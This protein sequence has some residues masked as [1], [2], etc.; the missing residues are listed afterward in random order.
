[1]AWPKGQ[2]RPLGAGRQKGT[3]NIRTAQVME[4]LSK[5]KGG[6]GKL[7]FNPLVELVECYH[8][9]AN[10]DGVMHVAVKC[11][12]ILMPYVY[13]KITNDNV[14]TAADMALVEQIKELAARPKQE[15][16]DITKA[17]LKK[18]E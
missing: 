16:I 3:R 4:I 11:L 7:G 8:R 6:D 13:P 12:D 5:L 1:M 18:V 10:T 14:L 15:I 17:E 2:P 9:C